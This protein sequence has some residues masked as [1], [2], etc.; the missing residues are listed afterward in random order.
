MDIV[1]TIRLVAV[2][3]AVVAA[4][5]NFP[6]E[7]AIIAVLGLV[8]GYFVEEERATAFLVMAI[9]LALVHGALGPVWVIGSYLTDILGSISSLVN[10]AACTVIS[11]GI[12]RGLKA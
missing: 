4:F 10:A 5:V 11:V 9:A 7:A 6:Q 8:V 12:Y 1:R 2:P 3:I